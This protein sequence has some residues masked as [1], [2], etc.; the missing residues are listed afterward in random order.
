MHSPD[1]LGLKIK[2]N[3]NSIIT[4]KILATN[5]AF[6]H[7]QPS[8]QLQVLTITVKKVTAQHG[9]IICTEAHAACRPRHM[10]V[11]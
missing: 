7:F 3:D 6:A 2:N 4:K 5:I 11:L 10:I 8:S 9:D 1:E